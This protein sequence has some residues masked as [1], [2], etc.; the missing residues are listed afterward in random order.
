M[1]SWIQKKLDTTTM[2][3][4]VMLSLG[5]LI[6]Y[7]FVLACLD[8]LSFNPFALLVSFFVITLAALCT[9]YLCAYVR[10]IPLNTESTLITA[11]ILTLILAPS[12]A[13]IDLLIISGIAVLS[14]V[15]KF[16]LIYGKRHIFNP[17]ALALF[18]AGVLGYTGAEWWVSSRYM[19][20]IVLICGVL[21]TLKTQRIHIVLTY[22]VLSTA[23]VVML[24]VTDNAV[25]DAFIIHFLSWPTL[26]FAT[27]M[28]TE[29]LGIP[30][31]RRLQYVYAS[32]VATVGSI[33]FAIGPVYGTPELALLVGNVYTLIV[34]RPVRFILTFKERKE[35]GKNTY[36]YLFTASKNVVHT[37]GQYM[38]WTLPH[39]P[40][41]TRGIRRY[42]TI[43][44]KAERSPSVSFSVR[45]PQVE[46]S[47]KRALSTLKL[48]DAM[49]ATQ[50]AGDFVLER[51]NTPYVWI[52][53]GIGIT[54]F[55][56]MI[57]TISGTDTNKI[58]ATL[59]YC[60]KS[61]D[62]IAFK[63]E[64]EAAHEK[65]LKT[66]YMLDDTTGAGGLYESGFITPEIIKKHV[67]DWEQMTF[68]IAGPPML[69][70]SYESMLR[71]MG[72]KPSRIIIDYFPGL[73]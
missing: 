9:Q 59:F 45:H 4:V 58:P 14:I 27:V 54:P 43:V 40:V 22:V 52:A 19:L 39:A 20:P 71:K 51:H 50:K 69:I 36:E 41:D 60:N 65:G 56:S 15:L 25:F 63:D 24:A 57:R 33:P 17:A 55:I 6:L 34:D 35:V 28:L 13:L 31:T 23:I 7:A 66:V 68:Y 8:V 73:A 30:S 53:G 29:P 11:G 21:I 46:S 48:G 1:I 70:D 42:L 5:T 47:W 49:Y 61:F 37:A 64:I 16:V 38:E 2:Y 3:R 62:D 67:S 10:R 32:I 44:S 18:A 26:F 12:L 72:V